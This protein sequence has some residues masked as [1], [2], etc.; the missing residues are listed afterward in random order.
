MSVTL[1]S[2]QE[3]FKSELTGWNNTI[4]IY[5]YSRERERERERERQTDRTRQSYKQ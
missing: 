2:L 4:Y 3:N 5:I 1:S